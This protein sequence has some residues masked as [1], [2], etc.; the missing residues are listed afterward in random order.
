[1]FSSFFGNIFAVA[2]CLIQ[3]IGG[4]IHETLI[5]REVIV[6]RIFVRQKKYCSLV[7]FKCVSM[8]KEH[9]ALVYNSNWLLILMR[10]RTT[11][12]REEKYTTISLLLLYVVLLADITS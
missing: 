1:M 2:V 6:V 11:N 3:C 5:V 12:K 7:S 9:K 10:M 4:G 8:I